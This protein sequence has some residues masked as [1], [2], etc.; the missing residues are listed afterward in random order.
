MHVA[1]AARNSN[2]SAS[3]TYYST[4]PRSL[5]AQTRR[6]VAATWWYNP[7]ADCLLN[8]RKICTFREFLMR[9]ITWRKNCNILFIA[10]GF[11]LSF[12]RAFGEALYRVTGNWLLIFYLVNFVHLSKRTNRARTNRA[13]IMTRFRAASNV[14]SPTNGWSV[15]RIMGCILYWQ[16][17]IFHGWNQF[18]SIMSVIVCLDRSGTSRNFNITPAVLY[19]HSRASI[20]IL[21]KY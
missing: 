15:F 14:S 17:A 11:L 6:D 7:G 9:V 10:S 4:L 18:C 5:A 8:K 13:R 1:F 21:W 3:R 12:Q 16:P 19:Y 2:Q 20:P